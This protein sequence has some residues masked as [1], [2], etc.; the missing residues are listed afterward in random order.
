MTVLA[1]L[2]ADSVQTASYKLEERLLCYCIDVDA[3]TTSTACC[4]LDLQ[5][6]IRSSVEASEYSP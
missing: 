4:D 2:L 5:N 6:L 1:H 3:F